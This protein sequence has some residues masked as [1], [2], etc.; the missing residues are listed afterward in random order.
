MKFILLVILKSFFWV[1][2]IY[3]TSYVI[4]SVT[5]LKLFIYNFTWK[6]NPIRAQ[7]AAV[8]DAFTIFF[9]THLINLIIS[10]SKTE[11][12]PAGYWYVIWFVI[13]AF[14]THLFQKLYLK[15]TAID[16]NKSY[17]DLS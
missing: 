5:F 9:P 4:E 11:N 17:H 2:V 13:V 16:P 10:I 8:F 6:K 3:L 7:G 14:L 15:Y 1:F 12:T